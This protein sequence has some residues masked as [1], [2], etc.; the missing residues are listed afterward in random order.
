MSGTLFL[1]TIRY[2]N[3]L[4]NEGFLTAEKVEKLAQFTLELETEPAKKS[5]LIQS[6]AMPFAPDEALMKYV[7]NISNSV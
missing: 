2:L 5:D 3:C 7:S 1:Q 6:G 4:Y